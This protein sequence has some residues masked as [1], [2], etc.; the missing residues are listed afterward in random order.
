M[1][2]ILFAA[3]CT[4]C[5]TCF[6][7]DVVIMCPA[8]IRV[9]A[10]PISI[11]EL[12][13]GYQASLALRVL[14]L[15]YGSLYSGPPEL[16]AQLIGEKPPAGAIGSWELHKIPPET[17]VSDARMVDFWASCSYGDGLVQVAKKVEGDNLR[18]CI[19][20]EVNPRSRSLQ[21]SRQLGFFCN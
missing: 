1:R 8:E 11:S 20:K 3:I 14:K 2:R 18:R 6:A 19:L 13:T 12:P 10:M 5:S 4:F 21:K 9:E 7:G 17:P 16:R 15:D